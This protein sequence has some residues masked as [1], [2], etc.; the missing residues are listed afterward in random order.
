MTS[1]RFLVYQKTQ[2]INKLKKLITSCHSSGILTKTLTTKKNL[3]R[4]SRKFLMPMES[5]VMKTKGKNMT[6]TVEPISSKAAE[7][8]VAAPSKEEGED[9]VTLTSLNSTVLI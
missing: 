7:V 2:V 9:S 4:F 8:V 5:S 1:T 6:C 3:R